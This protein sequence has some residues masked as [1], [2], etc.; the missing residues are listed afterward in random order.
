MDPWSY[1][2]KP[3][4]EVVFWE[5][6]G[7]IIEELEMVGFRVRMVRVRG[8]GVDREVVDT[9]RGEFRGEKGQKVLE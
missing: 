1:A 9:T 5:G 2:D 3:L 6:E 7:G 4:L 8:E